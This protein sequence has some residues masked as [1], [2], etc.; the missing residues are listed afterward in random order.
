MVGPACYP[1]RVAPIP[2]DCS[3]SLLPLPLLHA[4]DVIECPVC[5]RKVGLRDPPP[6][7][8]KDPWQGDQSPRITPHWSP[9]VKEP[10][11]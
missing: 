8:F 11:N 4:G 10:G 1:P 2:L 5:G 6:D 3:A 9:R 7:G